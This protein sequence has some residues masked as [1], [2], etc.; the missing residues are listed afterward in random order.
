MGIAEANM[1]S[2]VAGLAQIGKIPFANSF[3]VFDLIKKNINNL[4][5]SLA[6]KKVVN[7]EIQDAVKG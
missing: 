7:G 2:T 5:D 1:T 6:Q 3:A 4:I